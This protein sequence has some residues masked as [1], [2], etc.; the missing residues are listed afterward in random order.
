[1]LRDVT[2]II[3][4]CC[5]KVVIASLKLFVLLS[6]DRYIAIKHSFGYQNLV[7]EVR[8]ILASGLAWTAASSFPWTTSGQQTH[9]M[10]QNSRCHSA[11]YL[12]CI[13]LFLT[14]RCTGKSAAS[15]DVNCVCLCFLVFFLP[16]FCLLTELYCPSPPYTLLPTKVLKLV[17]TIQFHLAR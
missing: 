16:Q 5:H 9:N 8:I 12:S 6:A 1:M 13:T 4:S 17:S 15:S 14:F 7:T 3:Y 10:Q 2:C 11:V